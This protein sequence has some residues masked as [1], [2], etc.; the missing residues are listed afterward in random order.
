MI[1]LRSP[2]PSSK[3]M[4]RQWYMAENSCCASRLN[5]GPDSQA[6]AC[7]GHNEHAQP[8]DKSRCR[9][10][11]AARACGSNGQS[12]LIRRR[13]GRIDGSVPTI[14]R[15]AIG[16]YLR[17]S[18]ARSQHRS[19]KDCATDARWPHICATVAPRSDIVTIGDDAVPRAVSIAQIEGRQVRIGRIRGIGQIDDERSRVHGS[20]A[21]V[22]RVAA[23]KCWPFVESKIDKRVLAWYRG[24]CR[25]VFKST[26]QGS[27]IRGH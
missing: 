5:A 4:I 23:K 6:D 22:R 21:V 25:S 13:C 26:I 1:R 7:N 27:L 8:R 15:K 17:H 9:V 2:K 14:R 18:R 12:R 20:D 24:K 10:L 11:G 19:L 3:C 16:T